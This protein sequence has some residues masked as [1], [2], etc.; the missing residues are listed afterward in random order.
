MPKSRHR[1]CERNQ[2]TFQV[3]ANRSSMKRLN[4]ICLHRENSSRIRP[5]RFRLCVCVLAETNSQ[6]TVTVD[7]VLV[8]GCGAGYGRDGRRGFAGNQ[9]VWLHGGPAD[10]HDALGVARGSQAMDV[11]QR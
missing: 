11:S 4:R 3:L 1:G 6:R 2:M 9:Q 5:M 7:W 10:V 8:L